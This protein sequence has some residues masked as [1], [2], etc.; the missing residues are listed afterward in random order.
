MDSEIVIL[1]LPTAHGYRH[2]HTD[3]DICT[4]MQ[5]YAHEYTDEALHLLTT[6][7]LIPPLP[8][9]STLGVS[10]CVCVCVSVSVCVGDRR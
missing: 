7:D 5:T 9:P 1:R 8:H 2:M 6:N 4:P 10:V 3:T